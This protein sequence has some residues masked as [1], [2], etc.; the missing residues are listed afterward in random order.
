LFSFLQI[1]RIGGA[2]NQV[3]PGKSPNPVLIGPVL[4]IYACIGGKKLCIF[5]CFFSFYQGYSYNLFEKT[6]CAGAFLF[7]YNLEGHGK[8]A[9]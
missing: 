4:W 2:L 8:V 5:F 7:I 6:W 3:L 9:T 1:V